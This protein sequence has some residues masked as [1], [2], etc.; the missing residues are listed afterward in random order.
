[1]QLLCCILYFLIFLLFPSHALCKSERDIKD[2]K[3]NKN[4][5][6]IESNI[7]SLSNDKVITLI[8]HSNEQF[9]N[10]PDMKFVIYINKTKKSIR[11]V[12]VKGYCNIDESNRNTDLDYMIDLNYVIDKKNQYKKSEY[13]TPEYFNHFQRSGALGINISDVL[14]FLDKIKNSKTF[15]ISFKYFSELYT[16][17]FNVENI[18]DLI[19]QY[20]FESKSNPELKTVSNELVHP[21]I[22]TISQI[23][24]FQNEYKKLFRDVNFKIYKIDN[25]E[26]ATLIKYSKQLHDI[27]D[28][29]NTIFNFILMNNKSGNEK[30][31][32]QK[33]I[34]INYARDYCAS[35]F[36]HDGLS[37]ENAYI[38]AMQFRYKELLGILKNINN[39]NLKRN[40][41]VKPDYFIEKEDYAK[42]I[43]HVR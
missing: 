16:Y 2:H 40:T 34:W 38:K 43:T 41:I 37:K 12:F 32:K 28:N 3:F 23:N 1:M 19:N 24:N 8:K 11:G 29:V 33:E 14:S 22:N 15:S 20:Y 36:I 21:N 5:I 9:Y 39:K 42:S 31:L 10:M 27:D 6:I 13:I 4:W 17:T 26:Y 30:I 7:D 35:A 18:N 25:S